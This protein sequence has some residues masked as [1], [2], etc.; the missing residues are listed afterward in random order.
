[1]LVTDFDFELPADLIAQHP[2]ERGQSR[3]L[4]LAAKG[5]KRHRRISDLPGL[6]RPG[7]LLVVNDTRVIPA[8]LHA[9]RRSG[10]GRVEVLL[11]ERR[12]EVSWEVLLKPGRRSKPGTVL[13]FEAADLLAE[14]VG[15]VGEGRFLL[16]FSQAIEPFLDELGHLPLPPYIKRPDQAL[17]RERYQTVYARQTGA[18]AAPTAGLHFTPEL[19]AELSVSGIGLAQVTLHVGLGTFQPVAVE[20]VEEHR[21]HS[22]RY[23][24]PAATAAAIRDTQA[25]GGRIIAV[26]TTVVRTLETVAAEHDEIRPGEGRSNLFI[27]PGF[28]FRVVDAVLTNFHLPRSTLL[29]LVAAFVGREAILDAYREAVCSGYRFFSYGDAMFL[30]RRDH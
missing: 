17:D 29:M 13:T 14:V 30:E 27:T 2:G 24:V 11:L 26:G 16:R 22:E 1:M 4:V 12:D 19:L 3:L 10:G 9:R 28:E 18:V 8:R 20:R 7:D 5:E 23:A 21:M 15:R 6:L 25:R